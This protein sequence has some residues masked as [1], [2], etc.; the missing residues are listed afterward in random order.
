MKSADR[1]RVGFDGGHRYM[2]GYWKIPA[3]PYHVSD[4][5]IKVVTRELTRPFEVTKGRVF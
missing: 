2:P 3:E 5:G 4:T 1:Y